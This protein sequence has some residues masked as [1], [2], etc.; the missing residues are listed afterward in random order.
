MHVA[1]KYCFSNRVLL[2]LSGDEVARK[3]N[4]PTTGPFWAT[5]MSRNKMVKILWD[6]YKERVNIQQLRPAI[7]SVINNYKIAKLAYIL[8]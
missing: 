1:H 8:I 4:A 3:L 6:G 5:G 7:N 2:V